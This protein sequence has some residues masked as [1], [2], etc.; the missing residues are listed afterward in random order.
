MKAYPKFTNQ[1]SSRIQ[2]LHDYVTNNALR[3]T[4]K[5]NRLRIKLGAYRL[6]VFNKI[7]VKI[8]PFL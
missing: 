3:E 2:L 5:R 1:V 6:L 8:L 7:K 4:E